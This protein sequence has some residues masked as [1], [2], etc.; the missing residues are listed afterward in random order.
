MLWRNI[1]NIAKNPKKSDVVQ[2]VLSTAEYSTTI[3]RLSKLKQVSMQ[4]VKKLKHD[5]NTSVHFIFKTPF[6]NGPTK[7][8]G[9]IPKTFNQK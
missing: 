2:A 7:D 3:S 5:N 4:T 1:I 6:S 9:K 8:I